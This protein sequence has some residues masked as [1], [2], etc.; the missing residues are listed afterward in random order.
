MLYPYVW[1]GFSIPARPGGWKLFTKE[2]EHA[3]AG[4]R[5]FRVFVCDYQLTCIA[6]KLGPVCLHTQCVWAMSSN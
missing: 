3:A 6:L 5:L 1:A 4:L 2:L